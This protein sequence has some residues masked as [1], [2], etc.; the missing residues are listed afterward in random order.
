MSSDSESEILDLENFA[1]VS[2]P[3][4]VSG[5]FPY[6]DCSSILGLEGCESSGHFSGHVEHP[7]C[8]KRVGQSWPGGVTLSFWSMG[9]GREEKPTH[10]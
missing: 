6:V 1:Q 7:V 10:E 9:L 3:A 2:R 4:A 5:I 8:H